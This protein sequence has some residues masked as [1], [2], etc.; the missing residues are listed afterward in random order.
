MHRS[1]PY[2]NSK[3]S[4][5]QYTIPPFLLLLHLCAGRHKLCLDLKVLLSAQPGNKE[6]LRNKPSQIKHISGK[7]YKGKATRWTITHGLMLLWFKD[8]MNVT[9]KLQF[10]D[11]TFGH[12]YL[13]PSLG[14]I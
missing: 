2:S 4:I 5:K 11:P 9:E 8:L 6:N 10:K 3:I 1:G 14:V 7:I 13:L 12:S